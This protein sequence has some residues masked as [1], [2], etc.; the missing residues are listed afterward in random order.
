MDF[1]KF[2]KQFVDAVRAKDI[3]EFNLERNEYGLLSLTMQS[4]CK[5]IGSLRV[6][7][8]PMEITFSCNVSHWHLYV[9]D[10]IRFDGSK[11]PRK[12]FIAKAIQNIIDFI[13]DRI[14]VS[15]SYA[16]DGREIS[17]GHQPR[18]EDDKLL[19]YRPI[20]HYEQHILDTYGAPAKYE[21]WVW[22]GS[23][24]YPKMASS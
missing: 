8:K 20:T 14:V 12:D 22:S 18:P 15:I 9:R 5:E 13:E 7:I 16:P 11:K 4:P 17:R 2:E 3:H 21:Y 6:Y 23:Y 1:T 24:D 10:I 19:P